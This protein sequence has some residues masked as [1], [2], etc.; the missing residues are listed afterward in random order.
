MQ[1][2]L[3]AQSYPH[4]IVENPELDLSF[5]FFVFFLSFGLL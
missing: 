2:F 4:Y 3:D 5:Y 1:K